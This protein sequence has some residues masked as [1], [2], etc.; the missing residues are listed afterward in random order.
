MHQLDQQ[1]SGVEALA[2]LAPDGVL[3]HLLDEA[4]HHRQRHVG[5]QQ[6]HAHLA[7]GIGDVLVG[8]VGLAAQA[9]YGRFEAF[10]EAVEH[11]RGRR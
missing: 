2:D 8:E 5:F 9:A 10:G 11:G 1:L 4:A 7:Q 3:P 6:R